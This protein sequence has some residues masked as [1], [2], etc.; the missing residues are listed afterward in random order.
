VKYLEILPSTFYITGTKYS[1]KYLEPVHALGWHLILAT[2]FSM[3][4]TFVL[5]C[6]FAGTQAEDSLYQLIFADPIHEGIL[7]LRSCILYFKGNKHNKLCQPID[8]ASMFL[9][10]VKCDYLMCERHHEMNESLAFFFWSWIFALYFYGSQAMQY[11]VPVFC[12]FLSAWFIARCCE[13]T[14]LYYPVDTITV[15]LLVWQFVGLMYA[16][17]MHKLPWFSLSLHQAS[18][19]V[20]LAFAAFYLYELCIRYL[21]VRF[22]LGFAWFLSIYDM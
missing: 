11:T 21:S 10:P 18:T 8:S 19:C 14:V 4:A 7:L 16:W 12:T 17:Q 22:R 20:L 6:R 13:G 2:S 5:Q 15:H 3:I 9:D 1:T